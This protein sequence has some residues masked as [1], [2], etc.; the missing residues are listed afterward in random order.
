MLDIAEVRFC[1][2]AERL[3]EERLGFLVATLGRANLGQGGGC[4][5]S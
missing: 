3:P 1:D 4:R 2:S 5:R